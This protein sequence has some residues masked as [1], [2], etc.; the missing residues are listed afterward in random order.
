LELRPR[1]VK[2]SELGI[3]AHS[4]ELLVALC[5]KLGADTYRS[6]P[7]GEKYLEAGKFAQAGIALDVFQYWPKPYPQQW[8]DFVP[9]LSVIDMLFNCGAETVR[10]E[11]GPTR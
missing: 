11:I 10:Q 2:L 3:N 1:I 6:G 5:A 8:G 9:G 4:T 7:S